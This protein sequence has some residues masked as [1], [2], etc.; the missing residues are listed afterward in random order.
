MVTID[1]QNAASTYITVTGT[2]TLLYSLI[3]TAGS[4]T[5]SASYYV[6]KGANAVI[7]IPTS[8]DVSMLSGGTTPTATQGILMQ[9]NGFYYWPGLDIFTMKLIST[10]GGNVTVR[11]YVCKSQEGE[12]PTVI[13]PAS[14]SVSGTLDTNVKQYGGSAVGATNAIHTQPGTGAVFQVQSN[15]A[16]VA[17]ET[18]A[19]NINTEL[20][21]LNSLVPSKFDYIALSYTGSDLTGV[22]FKSGG[23]GGATVS[24]LT[25]AY[26]GSSNL[27]SVTKS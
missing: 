26:D 3:D 1:P 21:V 11:C 14:I 27:T 18:T 16:N 9:Q 6:G 17:T 5:T 2:A 12:N 25:L 13:P 8:G 4:V 15:S 20:Q 19:G 24:T 7:L 23:S 22:V 10:G